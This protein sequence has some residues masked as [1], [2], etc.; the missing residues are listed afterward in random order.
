MR[1][2]KKRILLFAITICM[3]FCL[4]ACKNENESVADTPAT[5]TTQTEKIT[6]TEPTE[7]TTTEATTTEPTTTTEETTTEATTTE[8]TTEETTEATTTL[9]PDT[10]TTTTQP[11]PQVPQFVDSYS[12]LGLD[13]DAV[14]SDI[15]MLKGFSDIP[16]I[17]VST[18]DKK[19]VVSLE[20]YLDCAVD[21][22]NCEDEYLIQGATAGIRVRGNS[23]AFYGD[24]NQ[25]LDNEVPYRIKFD[26][27]TSMLGL[28]DSA[29]CKSWVLLKANWNLV[30]DYTAFSMAEK[31]IENYSSDS[32]MVLV[33]I[34]SKYKG[35]YVLCEQNQVNENRV[36]V[37]EPEKNYQGTDIG[38]YLE[39]NNYAADDE[40]P[41][42]TVTY[43]YATVEDLEGTR[44]EFVPAEYSIKNDIYSDNQKRFIEKY[45][46]NVFKIMYYACE[47]N[48]YYA[49]DKNYN[50]VN[51]DYSNAYDCINAVADI[52]S[53]VNMYILYELVHDNDCGEGSFYMCVDFSKDSN[54]KKLT[55]ISPW[56]FNWAY[57][58]NPTHKYYAAAFNDM[59]FVNKYG[60][61]TNPWFVLLNTEDWFV[62]LV[63]A[64]WNEIGANTILNVLSDI[65]AE[66]EAN[67][68]DFSLT[69]EWQV[70]SAMDLL[71]WV[72]NR[73][74]WLD[75]EW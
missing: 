4:S 54:Y 27:K 55:F 46:S 69:A 59:S 21:V 50:L 53:I 5:T 64:R 63:K 52:D 12:E 9:A 42:F 11:E 47:K 16:V 13:V 67:R 1:N 18:K 60:D 17:F 43:E 8:T 33:F 72:R 34:N 7:V 32:K 35:I 74:N 62:D 39:L 71:K 24:V 15:E 51:S 65:E 37:F 28:N 36:D 25:I 57:D 19:P 73:V 49:L 38:Y 10:V 58:G 75:T 68:D 40:D 56:D 20:E 26:E 3:A 44:R 29:E 2:L 23:T 31:I 30:M 66:L 6:T 41:Y 70:G 48:T 61:R 14:K 22:F 45:V